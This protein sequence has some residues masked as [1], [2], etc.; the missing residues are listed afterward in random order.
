V[1]VAC[2]D[3][4][5][6]QPQARYDTPGVATATATATD[7]DRDRDMHDVMARCIT[8]RTMSTTS[9]VGPLPASDFHAD[10]SG[11]MPATHDTSTV[12]G[13]QRMSLLGADTTHTHVHTHRHARTHTHTLAHTHT[14]THTQR[15]TGHTRNR[16][17]C[18]RELCRRDAVIWAQTTSDVAADEATECPRCLTLCNIHGTHHSS[19]VTIIITRVHASARWSPNPSTRTCLCPRE[20]GR[21]RCTC[22]LR[23]GCGSLAAFDSLHKGV[24]AAS[25][26]TTQER[27]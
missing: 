16:L 15:R 17:Q 24:T 11:L 14:H 2:R 21:Q 18:E 13:R 8:V 19:A 9:R 20:R 10:V 12:E 25:R 26:L 4:I 27:R 3:T 5:T 1:V 23:Q 7:A 6:A 22:T